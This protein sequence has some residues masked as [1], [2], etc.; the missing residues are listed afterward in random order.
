MLHNYYSYLLSILLEPSYLG[1]IL[2]SCIA[3]LVSCDFHNLL[4]Y[5]KYV[6]HILTVPLNAYLSLATRPLCVA[7]LESFVLCHYEP[8]SSSLALLIWF[9]FPSTRM[10]LSLVGSFPRLDASMNLFFLLHSSSC[11]SSRCFLVRRQNNLNSWRIGILE[12]F[13]TI[14]F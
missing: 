13:T 8:S 12:I 6:L 4:E 3:K 7:A 9:P 1:M 10:H 5:S 2:S 11:L 14:S